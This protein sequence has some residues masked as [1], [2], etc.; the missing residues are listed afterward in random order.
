[1]LEEFKKF[2][3]R[4]NVVDLA[5]GVIIGVAFGAIVN[6]L[7]ADIIMP[8]IGAVTGGL[9][10]SNYFIPLSSKVT[11][12]SL[13]EAKKQG[14][15]WPGAAFVNT[16][17]VR[18]RRCRG[19]RGGRRR[20][21]RDRRR[22]QPHLDRLV[23]RRL[24]TSRAVPA[25]GLRQLVDAEHSRPGLDQGQLRDRADRGGGQDLGLPRAWRQRHRRRSRLLLAQRGIGR[26]VDAS[27][28][29]IRCARSTPVPRTSSRP[30]GRRTS[31]RNETVVV[32][33]SAAVPPAGAV[34]LVLNVTSTERTRRDTCAP[35]PPARHRH[36]RR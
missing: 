3:M 34:A 31:R 33:S 24:R 2:A 4:G 28:R 27:S 9:D 16:H 14:A 35:R 8:I 19:G 20:G 7:V 21:G 13:V 6:S 26:R 30:A 5:I 22:D 23:E 25:R 15:C 10:F 11:A 17:P 12:D 18:H 29:S 36:R 1:M 32:P